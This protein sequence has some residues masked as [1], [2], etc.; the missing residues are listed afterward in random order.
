MV[1]EWVGL[2]IDFVFI[3]AILTYLLIMLKR[4][5]GQRWAK[6]T[7]KFFLLSFNYSLS[8]AIVL[9]IGAALSII[10]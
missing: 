4:V 6:T 8:I 9:I 1:F 5:Y 10:V 2:Q 7:L 3:L